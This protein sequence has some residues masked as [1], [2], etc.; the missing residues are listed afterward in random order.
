M[1]YATEVILNFAFILEIMTLESVF[2]RDPHLLFQ[3]RVF[4]NI[5]NL[6]S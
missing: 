5:I 3:E 1:I 6:H 2:G 4:A